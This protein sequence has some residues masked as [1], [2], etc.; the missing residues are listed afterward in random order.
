MRFKKYRQLA[1]NSS[2]ILFKH[3]GEKNIVY[4][5]V[6]SD[7]PSTNQSLGMFINQSH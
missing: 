7:K 2:E 6:F 1:I 5:K 3:D 4:E